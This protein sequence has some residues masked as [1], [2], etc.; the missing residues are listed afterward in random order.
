[1]LDLFHC[2]GSAILTWS[3]FYFFHSKWIRCL[4]EQLFLWQWHQF[5]RVPVWR[6]WWAD[7][8]STNASLQFSLV[9]LLLQCCYYL[10]FFCQTVTWTCSVHHQRSRKSSMMKRRLF[11][12]TLSVFSLSCFLCE[13]HTMKHLIFP[14]DTNWHPPSSAHHPPAWW[15]L[16]RGGSPGSWICSSV[17]HYKYQQLCKPACCL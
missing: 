4:Y 14:S 9:L 12:I 6:F 8:Q 11:L 7:L 17:L 1:M 2:F 5:C 15:L 13:G 3:Y 16:W 10:L